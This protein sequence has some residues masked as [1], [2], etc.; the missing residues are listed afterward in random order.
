MKRVL[1]VLLLEDNEDHAALILRN[2]RRRADYSLDVTVRQCTLLHDAL[3]ALSE[4]S[5]DVIISD[6]S[7]P[8]SDLNETLPALLDGAA[9]TPVVVLTSLD[10]AEFGMQLVQQGAQD[11]LVKS[12]ISGPLIARSLLYAIER[13]QREVQQKRHSEQLE[14]LVELRTR[15]LRLLLSIADVSHQAQSVREALQQSVDHI[16]STLKLPFGT[17]VL[18]PVPSSA[19]IQDIGVEFDG[20][21]GHTELPLQD[22]PDRDRR[23][24]LAIDQQSV[25]AEPGTTGFVIVVP[26]TAG[27]TVPALMEFRSASPPDEVESV[28]SLLER[29]R[30]QIGRVFERNQ[31]HR[32]L[33]EAEHV[34][35]QALIGELHDGL[36]HELSG[37]TWLAHSH[38]L[39]L[40]ESD[41]EESQSAEHLHDG[42]RD[43]LKS[44]RQTLRGLVSLQI[45][46]GG[47][48]PALASLVRE[49]NRRSDC[50]IEFDCGQTV[51]PISE[52]VATQVYRIVQES[53]TN[54]VRHSKA[55]RA[56]VTVV[57]RPQRFTV[58]I[59]DN[60]CGF[61]STG[62]VDAGLGL[63]IMRHRSR[64]IGGELSIRESAEGGLQVVLEAPLVEDP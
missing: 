14:S 63:G 49:T 36:G 21:A 25:I 50:R 57:S 9:A 23:L 37:L 51:L 64:I 24:Q 33:E 20:A 10:D 61:P 8:D 42:L 2:L 1:D 11:F 62:E 30:T 39:R 4:D 29:I 44:L 7:L 47:F 35:Q 32:H 27:R 5:F 12:S 13:K 40:R 3:K 48:I 58:S 19:Q 54:V 28:S 45:G 60:G 41:S 55:T 6:L 31:F 53:L 18:L 43:A 56:C 26:I 15:H 16:C 38:L 22:D 52:F 46:P 17:A 59:A 34:Q